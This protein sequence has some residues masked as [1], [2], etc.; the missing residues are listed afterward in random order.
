MKQLQNLQHTFQNCVL[1]PGDS[2]SADWVSASGRAT[3]E[4]QLSIYGYAYAARLREVLMNDFPAMLMALGEDQFTILAN[5]YINE[6]PSKYF[7]L[8]DF[9]CDMPKFVL[10]QAG[11]NKH[12]LHELSL[13]EWT[14][15]QAFD[16]ADDI[17]FSEL[18]MATIPADAW[19][20]L[21]LIFHSSVQRLDF[22]WN[23][24]DMWQALTS[25][26]PSEVI[27]L[28]EESSSWLIW[29]N[30][31]VTRF[32]SLPSDEQLALDTALNGGSFNDVCE[33]LACIMN[34]EDVPMHAASLL[35]GWIS[36]G[37]ICAVA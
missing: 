35:K 27:A 28:P 36:T 33:R 6:Y 16:A 30:E 23:T 1:N 26:E 2:I 31:L 18:D 20:D 24:T 21:K 15:G 10:K 4:V 7:S 11:E 29:R 3:P 13:F 9:S 19:F 14:L 5:E 12:W 34:E 25:D 17:L 8:R 32:R 37:L 22:E